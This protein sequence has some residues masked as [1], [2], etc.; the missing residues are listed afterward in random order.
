L[1]IFFDSDIAGSLSSVL[2]P[3]TRDPGATLSQPRSLYPFMDEGNP[4][5]MKHHSMEMLQ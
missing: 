2:R 4:V 5:I 3:W 1:S